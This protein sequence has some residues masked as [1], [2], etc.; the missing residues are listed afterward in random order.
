MQAA[1][2]NCC[3]YCSWSGTNNRQLKHHVQTWHRLE[4]QVN[5][6]TFRGGD[7]SA[8]SYCCCCSLWHERGGDHVYS[9]LHGQQPPCTCCIMVDGGSLVPQEGTP[10]LSSSAGGGAHGSAAT[11]GTGDG[12]SSSMSSSNNISSPAAGSDGFGWQAAAPPALGD[13]GLIDVLPD[14]GL[15]WLFGRDDTTKIAASEPHELLGEVLLAAF[16]LNGRGRPRKEDASPMSDTEW[17]PLRSRNHRN[18]NRWRVVS[19]SDGGAVTVYDIDR[20]ESYEEASSQGRPIDKPIQTYSWS[21][22]EKYV[23]ILGHSDVNNNLPLSLSDDELRC[24]SC[25]ATASEL[26]GRAKLRTCDGNYPTMLVL[27]ATAD[28]K[29][30]HFRCLRGAVC[31]SCES[32]T[33]M[34]A[35]WLCGACQNIDCATYFDCWGERVIPPASTSGALLPGTPVT[36]LA[37][38]AATAEAPAVRARRGEASRAGGFDAAVGRFERYGGAAAVEASADLLGTFR[39]RNLS[40]GDQQAVLKSLGRMHSKGYISGPRGEANKF[41]IPTDLRTLVVRGE[42]SL[43]CDSE[44]LHR[45]ERIDISDLRQLQQECVIAV[46]DLPMLLQSLL[47][48]PRIPPEDWF[49]GQPFREYTD[50]HGEKLVGPEMWQGGSRMRTVQATAP[51]G[52]VVL[53]LNVWSDVVAAQSGD[54]YP[55]K[56]TIANMASRS[57]CADRGSR[58]A[59]LLPT[60]RLRKPRG[61]N[62]SERLKPYQARV[63]AQALCDAPAAALAELDALAG[64]PVVHRIDGQDVGVHYRLALYNSDKKEETDVLGQ[65]KDS[66]PRCF[67]FAHAFGDEQRQGRGLGLHGKHFAHLRV[68]HRSK[69]PTADA[70]TPEAVLQHQVRLSFAAKWGSRAE[71]LAAEK[72]ARRLGVRLDVE[73]QLNRLTRLAPWESGGAYAAFQTDFLHVVGTGIARVFLK[74]VDILIC[75]E[76]KLAGTAKSYEDCRHEVEEHLSKI[77]AMSTPSHRLTQFRL[78]WWSEEMGAVSASDYLAF[79]DQLLFVYVGNSSL[80]PDRAKRKKLAAVHQRLHQVYRVLVTPQWMTHSEIDEFD[81]S[82]DRCAEDFRWIHAELGCTASSASGEESEDETGQ[83]DGGGETEEEDDSDEGAE[84]GDCGAPSSEVPGDGFNIPK[85]HDFLNY[86]RVIREIGWPLNACTSFFERMNKNLKQADRLTRRDDLHGQHAVDVLVRNGRLEMQHAAAAAP[87]AGAMRAAK[88]HRSAPCG[89]EGLGAGAVFL[90][91]A[92][93]S[94]CSPEELESELRVLLGV[95]AGGEV[96]VCR[97]ATLYYPGNGGQGTMLS[98]GHS[99]RLRAGGMYAYICCL[100]VDPSGRVVLAAKRYVSIG[101]HPE[102]SLKWFHR[103]E[104]IHLVPLENVERREHLVEIAPGARPAAGGPGGKFDAAA[105]QYLLNTSLF[106]YKEKVRG[107]ENVWSSCPREMCAGKV[108]RPQLGQGSMVACAQCGLVFPWL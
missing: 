31:E 8:L 102:C 40:Q 34:G 91:S 49:L 20:Y 108:Q 65:R 16:P 15:D 83:A 48:D 29:G 28:S 75:K 17:L 85:V 32:S 6:G 98:A 2:H 14:D 87:D 105:A 88:R 99:V 97:S 74:M 95:P 93:A 70:R 25:L 11:A 89:C 27:G 21:E 66:C 64:S 30:G 81:K 44:V 4:E 12:A 37:A 69:C 61:S 52:S 60:I 104:D 84:G 54:L 51:P 101:R 77:P 103:D 58:T 107:A 92:A 76:A 45:Q 73:T 22:I 72:E 53:Q 5:N 94:G 50:E 82:L 3:S 1:D 90:D 71:S 42:A 56:I 13:G 59:A 100:L 24:D 43:P 63:K 86:A 10:S 55:M 62:R 79:F 9:Q 23:V 19:V 18:F 41:P 36:A 57:R 47:D 26:G 106:Y 78:G 7:T 80:L 68:D 38:G 39:D 96:D 35:N 46:A 67:G 33:A